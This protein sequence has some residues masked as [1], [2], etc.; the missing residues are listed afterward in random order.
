MIR[1]SSPDRALVRPSVIVDVP[2]R[3][4]TLVGR[5]R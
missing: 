4:L 3:V 1:R 5:A 2:V